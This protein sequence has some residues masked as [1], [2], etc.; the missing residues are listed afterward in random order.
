[1]ELNEQITRIKEMMGVLSEQTEETY[2]Y[3]RI[4]VGPKWVTFKELDKTFVPNDT[5]VIRFTGPDGEFTF[6]PGQKVMRSINRGNEAY[7]LKS[8]VPNIQQQE[9][10]NCGDYE[11]EVSKESF[12]KKLQEFYK[13]K[14]NFKFRNTPIQTLWLENE[15]EASEEQKRQ[16]EEGL[17]ILMSMGKINENEKQTLINKIL[18]KSKFVLD[19][20]GNWLPINK[21]TGN[22]V[23]YVEIITDIIFKNINDKESK[24][25]YCKVMNGENPNTI[26]NE[27]Y[28]SYL[29]N[30]LMG[31]GFDW[32]KGQT[33][34]IDLFSWG[35]NKVEENFGSFLFLNYPKHKILY[36]G[37]DGNLVDINL[38]I[39]MIVDLGTEDG[40]KAVQ[41]K[42]NKAGADTLLSKYSSSSDFY[43][44]LDWVVY[45]E[46][47]RWYVIDL[48]TGVSEQ[49]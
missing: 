35:G 24:E 7:T 8:N 40:V 16:L 15:S 49:L 36:K 45:P 26:L 2:S 1:M 48:T 34:K 10:L 30:K 20:N 4:Y 38:S 14:F 27:T 3:S 19:E 32:L 41:V 25:I 22:N 43:K 44:Y 5:S 21:L 13:V 46:N 17:D 29:E 33:N 18:Q 47:D 42:T 37:G 31:M 12:K 9:V 23:Q 39:D 11:G 28:K 6:Q